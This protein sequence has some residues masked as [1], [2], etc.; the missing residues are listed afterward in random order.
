MR[1]RWFG[2]SRARS[3]VTGSS[4]AFGSPVALNQIAPSVVSSR[5]RLKVG[6]AF[7]PGCESDT[8]SEEVVH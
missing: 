3:S 8:Y 7:L 6:L 2:N 4:C 5:M 1:G